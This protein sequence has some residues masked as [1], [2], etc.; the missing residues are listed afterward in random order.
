M[1][2]DMRRRQLRRIQCD[3]YI[4]V[5]EESRDGGRT[6]R[7]LDYKRHRARRELRPWVRNVLG[8]LFLLVAFGVLYVA[9]IIC[10]G[11]PAR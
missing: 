11:G 2:R 5:I 6:W 1:V 4:D 10:A 8:A 9:C 7:V 3:R